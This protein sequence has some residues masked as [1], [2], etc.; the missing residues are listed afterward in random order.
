MDKIQKLLHKRTRSLDSSAYE[1]LPQ[2]ARRGILNALF[3]PKRDEELKD[4]GE[5]ALEHLARRLDK[6]RPDGPPIRTIGTRRVD[7]EA[8]HYEQVEVLPEWVKLAPRW[9]LRV[10]VEGKEIVVCLSDPPHITTDENRIIYCT[11]APFP[12]M[13]RALIFT[14]ALSC[15]IYERQSVCGH[16]SAKTTARTHYRTDVS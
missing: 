1:E 4:A 7:P 6:P 15:T 11:V 14:L 9:R 5:V 12:C 10:K 8:P 16:E 3:A 13:E 2:V